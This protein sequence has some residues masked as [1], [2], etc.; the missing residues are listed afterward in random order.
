MVTIL[1]RSFAVLLAVVFVSSLDAKEASAHNTLVS[2]NPVDGAT[3]AAAPSQWILTF[4]KS[5]P[6]TS[7]SGEI[8]KS[9]GVR[10]NLQQPVHGT[11]DNIIVF[12]L[13][14]NLI[15][16]N[17]A[18]WR[19]IGTDGHVISGRVTFSIGTNASTTNT[20]PVAAPIDMESDGESIVVVAS[21][22][23]LRV[24][25]YIALLLLIGVLFSEKFFLFG[26]SA[27]HISSRI[28]SIS[29]QGLAASAFL[30]SLIVVN[31]LRFP[32][33]AFWGGTLDALSTTPGA[34]SATKA[35]AGGVLAVLLSQRATT[36]NKQERL[37]AISVVL[38]LIAFA[39]G[40]HSR[41]EGAPW[42]GIPANMVHTT[43]VAI[44][45]GGLA[46]LVCVIAP[47]LSTSD[48]LFAFRQFGHIAQR[49]V[50]V[51][52]VAGTVQLLRIY[53]NPLSMFSSRHGL[54]LLLKM[55]IVGGMIYL[56]ARNR[57]SLM[58]S[59]A[60]D[61]RNGRITRRQIVKFSLF[62]IGFG[63]TVLGVTAVLVGV[64]PT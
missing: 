62:E 41:S 43:A 7:A 12:T 1:R 49:A 15:D 6:L 42:L 54:L 18:R 60:P 32:G 25:N 52:A 64:S 44:W 53:P 45:L 34:M 40:G 39:Y 3:L 23:A 28:A 37:I 63:L 61:G 2:T 16:T 58:W 9:D 48:A 59:D 57:R 19:L 51:L 55:C 13:P 4:D 38:Y 14:P 10:I 30:Q 21:R 47:R 24:F 11:N 46:V 50:I 33:S 31:D 20:S 26:Q 5:V 56:A 17:T 36:T 35:L 22:P 29:G 8:V 27:P